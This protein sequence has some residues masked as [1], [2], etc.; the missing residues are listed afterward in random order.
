VKWKVQ[1][2]RGFKVAKCDLEDRP[3]EAPDPRGRQLDIDLYLVDPNGERVAYGRDVGEP[4]DLR[5]HSAPARRLHARSH[6]ICDCRGRLYVDRHGDACDQRALSWPA[7]GRFRSVHYRP[8]IHVGHR[9]G[10]NSQ[11]A[12][13]AS[14]AAASSTTAAGSQRRDS[15]YAERDQS[16][17]PSGD[18]L[19]TDAL[20]VV[21]CDVL[22]RAV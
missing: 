20:D 17:A 13:H 7:S 9:S 22:S 18:F 5:V 14:V 6:G 2:S 21:V 11:V 15:G 3:R 12:M 1:G 19:E 10:R 16:S 4:R 8:D